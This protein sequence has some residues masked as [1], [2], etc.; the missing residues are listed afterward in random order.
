M[1]SAAEIK[2]SYPI[3]IAA[4]C[5]TSGTQHPALEHAVVA[6]KMTFNILSQYSELQYKETSFTLLLWECIPDME[7]WLNPKAIHTHWK[8]KIFRVVW[9]I[10]W[11]FENW[12][13][14]PVCTVKT[15]SKLGYFAFR[16]EIESI[17]WCCSLKWLLVQEKSL[18]L[19]W[20]YVR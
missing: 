5:H 1:T 16:I 20:N 18:E 6:C 3:T 7:S 15:L 10:V 2:Q 17:M 4:Y 12:F 11:A 9:I 19:P 8:K 13:P 14:I